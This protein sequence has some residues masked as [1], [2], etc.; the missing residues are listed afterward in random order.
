[1]GRE[2]GKF[3]FNM[4][5]FDMGVEITSRLS[6][7]ETRSAIDA[8]DQ[9]F[10]FVLIAERLDESLIL[11]KEHLCWEFKDIVFYDKNVRKVS[12]LT[13][14][15]K[16]MVDQLKVLN[17]ADVLLY[18]HFLE[19]HKKAVLQYG[20]EKMAIQV[21]LLK[22]YKQEYFSKCGI[23]Y[24]NEFTPSS[25]YKEDSDKVIGYTPS[26]HTCIDCALLTLPE[27]SL[28]DRVKERL[29]KIKNL[30]REQKAEM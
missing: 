8:A 2:R 27:N 5:L 28:I 6:A 1:M 22:Y 10:D 25:M 18:R 9:L 15:P 4:M 11:L 20:E 29:L 14:M 3:G 30:E 12:E 13:D 16:E 21:E 17:S 24:M 7:I 19:K 23:T 26:C